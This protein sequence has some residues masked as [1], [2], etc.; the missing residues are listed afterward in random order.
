MITETTA[1]SC[2][3]FGALST[4][5]GIAAGIGWM[6]CARLL[7]ASE[8]ALNIARYET[9]LANGM[10]D[11]F[12]IEM[13]LAEQ[14]AAIVTAER[15][16]CKLR[17]EQYASAWGRVMRLLRLAESANK[18]LRTAQLRAEL[19]ASVAEADRLAA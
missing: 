3:A 18:E 14:N 11:H 19:T 6:R 4:G 1:I 12:S 10:A 13:A 2:A 8:E 9:D 16:K 7:D 17:A 15:D 5:L